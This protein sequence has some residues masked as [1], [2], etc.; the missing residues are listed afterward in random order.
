MQSLLKPTGWPP[1]QRERSIYF[2]DLLNPVAETSTNTQTICFGEENNLTEVE[3]TQAGSD[4]IRLEMLRAM[5]RGGILWLTRACQGAWSSGKAPR[6]W[7]M[8]VIIPIHKKD[9][10]KEC[11]N[12]QGIS[13]PVYLIRCMP[14]V[15]KND[16]VKYLTQ[17][18]RRVGHGW[19]Q[20]T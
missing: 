4:Q 11:F 15:L 10:K 7:Q 3:V 2:K 18:F 19:K 9:D 16:A 13:L 6:D 1:N 14:N 8:G 17:S 20:L 12:Y 5:N